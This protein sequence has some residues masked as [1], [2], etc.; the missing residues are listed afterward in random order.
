MKYY[1]YK[2]SKSFINRKNITKIEWMKKY[3]KNS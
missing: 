2:A 1:T 3:V